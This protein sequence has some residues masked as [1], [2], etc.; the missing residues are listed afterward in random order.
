[1]RDSIEMGAAK[2][3]SL[4]DGLLN[5]SCWM[6]LVKLQNADELFHASA[7]WPLLPQSGEQAVVGV[8]PVCFPLP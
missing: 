4:I 3:E 5:L 1:M 7:I 2:A 8:R 6:L